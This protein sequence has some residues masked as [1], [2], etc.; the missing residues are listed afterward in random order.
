MKQN[1][2]N[3]IIIDESGSMY[4]IKDEAIGGVNETIQ[5]IM[6]AQRLHS[7]HQHFREKRNLLNKI[8]RMFN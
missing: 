3:L 1:V 8:K 7:E 5:V 6:S 4:N 2:Y